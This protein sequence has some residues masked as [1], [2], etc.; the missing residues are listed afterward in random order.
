MR[1]KKISLHTPLKAISTECRPWKLCGDSLNIGGFFYL[2][3]RFCELSPDLVVFLLLNTNME[4]S[5]I[6]AGF[7]A[8]FFF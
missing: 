5:L 6:S 1:A 3:T 7:I 8:I 2:Q 4:K